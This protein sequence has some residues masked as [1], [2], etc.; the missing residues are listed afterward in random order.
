M[1]WSFK[2]GTDAGSPFN[3]QDC[4]DTDKEQRNCNNHLGLTETVFTEFS[5]EEKAELEEK[6]AHS[7]FTLGGSPTIRLYECPLT[8]IRPETTDIIKLV[9]LIDETHSLLFD[10]GWGNQPAWLAEAY[11]LYKSLQNE[12]I[13]RGNKKP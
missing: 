1:R 6:K 10:G 9:C 3:C 11:S 7:I 2:I 12:E 13:K 5:D 4:S 8:C